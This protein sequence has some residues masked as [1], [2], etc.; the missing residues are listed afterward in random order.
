[1]FDQNEDELENY[2]FSKNADIFVILIDQEN[3]VFEKEKEI[4]PIKTESDE[5]I[6][7]TY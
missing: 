4:V 5:G 3:Q 6:E 2:E 7:Y 1:M